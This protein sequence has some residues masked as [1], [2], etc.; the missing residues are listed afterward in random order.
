MNGDE[1]TLAAPAP[2]QIVYALGE[3]GYG[4]SSP[5]RRASFQQRI[6]GDA[7][8]DRPATLLNHLDEH[9]EDATAVQWTLILEGV[10]IYFL[11][12]AGPFAAGTYALL[13]RFLREQL[14]E[15]VE[16]VSVPGIVTG[17][18]R[19]RSGQELPV[20]TPVQR[21]MYSWTTEAL[22]DRVVQASSGE[23]G[24][25]RRGA[26][27]LGVTHFLERV[28][29]EL[30]N[31]GRLPHDRAINF[32]ATNAFEVEKVYEQALGEDMELDTIDVEPSAISSPGT[33]CW[34]VKL[35]FFFPAR[36]ETTIRRQYRFTVDVSD[37]VPATVG[38]LRSWW[39]R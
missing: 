24:D 38:P 34:D 22:V 37:V 25:D 9:P 21:G 14:E 36:P 27:R 5:G 30:R 12:P 7:D 16:R 35:L 23:G 15:D 33:N 1:G 17:S 2:D 8:P 28:Y 19:H 11:N 26:V 3:I 20:I 32:A 31:V 10:P 18:A 29:Y 13:R 39:I 4:F 6:E